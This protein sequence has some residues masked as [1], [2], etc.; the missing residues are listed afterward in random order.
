[1]SITS[2]SAGP[3]LVLLFTLAGCETYSWV[4]PGATPIEQEHAETACEAQALK[5]L[6]PDNV[7]S[8]RYSSKDDTHNSRYS[9]ENIRD[10]NATQRE[11]LVKDCMYRK[12]WSR[13]QTS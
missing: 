11:V 7:R 13:I 8:S 9:S 12:G 4:K 3:L 6:P 10:A 1:M 5:E 2:L